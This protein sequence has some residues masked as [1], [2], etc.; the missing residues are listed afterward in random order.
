MVG[1]SASAPSTFTCVRC[2]DGIPAR[3]VNSSD[4]RAPS[5]PSATAGV[6]Q[7]RAE[8]YRRGLAGRLRAA[9]P[10]HRLPAPPKPNCEDGRLLYPGGSDL[11][12]IGF[13]DT[14][15]FDV[16]NP[17]KYGLGRSLSSSTHV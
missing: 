9:P 15:V 2:T 13:R 6:V 4:G 17:P 8:R 14:T 11:S 5:G 3:V 16:R 12:P 7:I 1:R 10:D